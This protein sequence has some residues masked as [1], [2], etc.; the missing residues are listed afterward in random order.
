M[1]GAAEEGLGRAEAGRGVRG[2][3]FS[4]AGTEGWMAAGAAAEG[5]VGNV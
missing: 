1:N 4:C 5:E 3:W 2:A